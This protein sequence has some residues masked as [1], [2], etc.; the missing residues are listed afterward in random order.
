M[1]LPHAAF[2]ELLIN[3]VDLGSHD[4]APTRVLR[5]LVWL[6]SGRGL[7]TNTADE[8]PGDVR[9]NEFGASRP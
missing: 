2:G 1:F 4:L 6:G 9:V 7:P 8:G 3:E 5:D